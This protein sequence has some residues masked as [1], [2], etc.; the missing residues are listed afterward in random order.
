MKEELNEEEMTGPPRIAWALTG[1][2]HYLDECIERLCQ[3]DDVD[4]FLSK[5]VEEVLTMY[6]F[7]ERLKLGGVRVYR[8]NTESAVPVGQFYLGRYRQLVI[9]PATSNTVAKCVA[10]ISDNLI[11]NLFAQAGKCRIPSVVFACDTEPVVITPA[12][13]QMV[14]VYPR[15]IDLECVERLGGYRGVDVV[16]SMAELEDALTRD[17]QWPT[18]SSS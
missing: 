3:L 12:P 9:A 16:K 13:G 1:S 8:D 14:T 15:D 10:G 2:G 7:R 11:T 4:V 18:E 5:A 6:R 17:S